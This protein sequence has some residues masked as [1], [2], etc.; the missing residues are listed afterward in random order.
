M[1]N[2]CF[3][4]G[5]AMCCIISSTSLFSCVT[6]VSLPYPWCA[7]TISG[8]HWLKASFSSDISRVVL[9]IQ[10]PSLDM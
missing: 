6:S 5:N 1:M 3:K 2:G 4:I 8:Y 9:H 7:P 10:Q